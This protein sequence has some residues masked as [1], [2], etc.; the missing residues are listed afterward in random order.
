V[1]CSAQYVAEKGARQAGIVFQLSSWKRVRQCE[2]QSN[3][4]SLGDLERRS[5]ALLTRFRTRHQAVSFLLLGAHELAALT[6]EESHPSLV[7]FS[8]PEQ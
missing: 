5:H 8:E 7:F 3:D 4:M 1:L 2:A 6:R